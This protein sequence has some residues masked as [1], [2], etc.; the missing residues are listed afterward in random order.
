M[1]ELSTD[2][3]Y[4]RVNKKKITSVE[5]EAISKLL[6]VRVPG[7]YF[8]SFYKRG[9]WDGFTK[10]YN[11]L[12]GQFY[13]GLIRFV[14][15]NLKDYQFTEIDLR[16]K[17]SSFNNSL[18][19]KG[20]TPRPY[21]EQM[22]EDAIKSERGIICAPPNAG[23]C[24]TEDSIIFLS[25]GLFKKVNEIL[26]GDKVLSLNE[27]LNQEEDIVEYV[28][29][30]GVKEVFEVVTKRGKRLTATKNH[31]ILTGAGFK[32]LSDLK[33]GE[34]VGTVRKLDVIS[35]NFE[36]ID[37]FKLIFLG[38][39]LSEGKYD[40]GVFFWNTDKE[41][42]KEYKEVAECFNDTEVIEDPDQ[43]NIKFLRLRRKNRGAYNK[44]VTG[45]YT[46][47][48]E[49]YDKDFLGRFK[50]GGKPWNF[51][52]RYKCKVLVQNKN[53]DGARIFLD[54]CGL[55]NK[56]SRYKEIPGFVFKLSDK[57]IALLLNRYFCGDGWYSGD[58][59]GFCS[60]SKKLVEQISYLLL[61]FGIFGTISSS[62]IKGKSYWFWG[63]THRDSIKRFITCI[64]IKTK[65]AKEYIILDNLSKKSER[66]KHDR[67]PLLRKD[68][69]DLLKQNGERHGWL[70]DG[71]YTSRYLAKKLQHHKMV[72]ILSSN[73]VLWDEIVSI[74][75]IGY[76]NTF[77]LTTKKN[78]NFVANLIYTHNTEVAAGVIQILGHPANFFTHRLTLL[79][80][81]KERFEARLGIKVG[82]V[83]RGEVHLEDVNVLSVASV[84]KRLD[85]PLIKDILKNF[86]IV[87]S[88]ECHHI[89]AQ[90]WTSC[91][92]ECG[93]YYR[94]GLSATPLLRDDISNMT[95]RGLLGDEIASVTN[96]QLI[97]WGIS[98]TPSVYLFEI[99]YPTLPRHYPYA[100]VYD[101]S[102]V[103]SEYRNGLIMSSAKKFVEIGKSVFIIVFRIQHG[104]ILTEML[105][106]AGVKAEFIS[107]EGS[108][109][110][111]NQQ[112]LKLFAEKKI[113]CVISTSISDE[114]LD[115]PAMDV[116]I[117][118]V[119]DKSALKTIQRVGRGLRKK[120]G[121]NVVTVVDFI[122]TNNP[123]LEKHSYS[124]LNTY[125]GM[126][127][128]IYEV[129]NNNWD[130]VEL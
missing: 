67:I 96:E 87:I 32:C 10:F 36:D 23:K 81:T 44:G 64:G 52:K 51:G 114:G 130:V 129:K 121:E 56:N 34:F 123:H 91:L 125:Y 79:H 83:G 118:G 12:T 94:Y 37:D 66:N 106:Q 41:I 122:D 89:S 103:L 90:T 42:L 8:S 77:N 26:L 54:S 5:V 99:K 110:E 69:K 63:T 126:G 75:S 43:G 92:K 48:I 113:P 60:A 97:E 1:F 127:M 104:Q 80:Q 70:N 2:N 17:V 107:G 35:D 86:P 102:I 116:L 7:Y 76:R 128:K 45:H 108:T 11:R 68:L 18:F 57:K 88:D 47:R 120:Q 46:Y 59:V 39:Y 117:I 29:F 53:I 71:G 55:K 3:L 93:A 4:T 101:E 15:S 9:L 28:F 84:A 33:V 30:D 62:I 115:V 78:N 16:K 82:I 72:R 38:Y 95:V 49:K 22:I 111:R 13:T 40:G 98:A 112:V 31:P 25:N 100:K 85:D 105:R 14:K 50:K 61:R 58:S 74:K 119:G 109:P 21:Q 24:L 65:K 19:L 124:R 73:Y 6:S 27:D 20:I